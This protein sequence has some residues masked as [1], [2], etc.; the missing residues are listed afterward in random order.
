M[1]F[2]KKMFQKFQKLQEFDN[3]GLTLVELLC[4]VAILSIVG[5]T[6][7]SVLIVSADSYNR[8]NSEIQAQQE[9]Q[10]VANQIDDLLIDATADV[11]YDTSAEPTLTIKQGGV[12]HTV[13]LKGNELYYSNGVDEQLLASGVRDFGVDDTEFAERGYIKLKMKMDRKFQ[14]YESVFAITARKKHTTA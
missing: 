13:V 4:S 2:I 1:R 5:M 14:N 9:A 8:S 11:H 7:S 3:R 6:I 12:T 10:L